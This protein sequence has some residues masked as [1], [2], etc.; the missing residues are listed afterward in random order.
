MAYFINIVF[1]GN[2]FPH[3]ITL[4]HRETER[5]KKGGGQGGG[6]W[7]KAV[8]SSRKPPSWGFRLWIRLLVCVWHLHESGTCISLIDRSI[9]E[10]GYANWK[11]FKK[12]LLLH[13]MGSNDMLTIILLINVTLWRSHHCSGVFCVTNYIFNKNRTPMTATVE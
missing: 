3:W 7:P 4:R 9:C 10:P 13:K 6:D 8:G 11:V 5:R 2:C 1:A 12:A